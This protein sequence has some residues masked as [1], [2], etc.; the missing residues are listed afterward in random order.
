MYTTELINVLH[1]PRL[2]LS[3]AI[4]LYIIQFTWVPTLLRYELAICRKF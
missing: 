1:A 4:A 2:Y 3:S